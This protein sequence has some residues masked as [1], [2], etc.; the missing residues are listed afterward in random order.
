MNPSRFLLCLLLAA[1]AS[2]GAHADDCHPQ[3]SPGASQFIV[4]YGSLMQD[5]SRRQTAPDAGEARP[6]RVRGFQRAWLAKGAPVGFSTTYLGVAAKPEAVM[7]AVIFAVR[8]AAE[9]ASLDRREVSYCRARV[10]AAQMAPLDGGPV[11]DGE[12]WVY[13]NQPERAAPPSAAF[14]IVQSYVDIF[15]SGCLHLERK[16][17][18]DGFARECVR[19]TAGWSRHWVNDRLFPRRPF[20]HQ[21]DAGAIDRLLDEEVPEYFRAMRIE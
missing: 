5:V 8:D 17:R 1:L 3:P 20:E 4:G 15:L 7:N 19:T 6:V 16:F 12:A 10:P 9:M 18:L 2:A 21:P 13:V 11:P 14:P